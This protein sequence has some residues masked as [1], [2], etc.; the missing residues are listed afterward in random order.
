[1]SAI[2][3]NNWVKCLF[4]LNQM[5]TPLNKTAIIP[6]NN[7]TNVFK[8]NTTKP[9]NPNS[10]WKAALNRVI[11]HEDDARCF[12]IDNH[13][14]QMLQ[15]SR[16]QSHRYCIVAKLY[17]HLFLQCCNQKI[18]NDDNI[19]ISKHYYTHWMPRNS[20]HLVSTV[21]TCVTIHSDSLL[22]IFSYMG[23]LKS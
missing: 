1:M 11:E 19:I 20:T 2:Y 23:F 3:H 12:N 9:L 17:S 16:V 18:I 10:Y 13:Y 6:F 21:S 14:M 8:K 4:Y 5:I 22:L 15:K 7:P